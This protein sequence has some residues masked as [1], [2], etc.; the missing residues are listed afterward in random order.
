MKLSVLLITYNHERFIAQ[1][2]DSIFMQEANFDYEIVVGEDCSTDKTREILKRYQK[3]YPGKMKLLLHEQNVGAAQNFLRAYEACTGEYVAYLDG[4]DYWTSPSKIQKQVDFLDQN[5]GCAICC[6][7]VRVEPEADPAGSYV[8]RI[9]GGRTIF[10]LRDLLDENLVPNCTA[11]FRNGLFGK[12]PDWYFYQKQGDWSFHLLNAEHGDI[13][14]LDEVMACYRAHTG[15]IWTSMSPAERAEST[16][17]TYEAFNRHLGFSYDGVICSRMARHYFELLD[18]YEA[19]GDQ[20]NLRRAAIRARS[21]L[22]RAREGE[23]VI[24]A[25]LGL[26]CYFPLLFRVLRRLKSVMSGS[27]GDRRSTCASPRQSED[28]LPP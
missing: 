28:R 15:G 9:P 21:V 24:L 22:F 14:Y 2:L 17:A 11:M 4:D 20:S 3:F 26:R 19:E 12:F 27:C 6:H 10:S 7:A 1:A 5:R 25:L 13:G 18:N 8:Y 23:P 16:I